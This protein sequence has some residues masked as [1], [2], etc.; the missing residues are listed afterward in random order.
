MK[1]IIVGAPGT[2][3]E[4]IAMKLQKETNLGAT[5]GWFPGGE[6]PIGFLADYRTELY[7][8]SSRAIS[9]TEDIILWHSLIDSVAYASLRL[10]GLI[11]FDS[12]NQQEMGRWGIVFD[13]CLSMLTD[14]YNS[15]LTLYV[16][17]K[18]DDQDS[19]DLDEALNATLNSFDIP[20]KTIDPQA[21]AGTWLSS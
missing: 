16:P 4:D 17:Y 12:T 11:N 13:A 5:S 3:K 6:I 8:A 21:E 18:G 15:D 14:G 19:K 1:Y 7:L 20:F 9:T 2:G 10:T